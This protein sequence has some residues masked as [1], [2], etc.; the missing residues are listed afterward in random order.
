MEKIS[1]LIREVKSK[2]NILSVFQICYY[3]LT[4]IAIFY[5]IIMTFGCFKDI[6]HLENLSA[7]IVFIPQILITIATF[8]LTIMFTVIQN[9]SKEYSDFKNLLSNEKTKIAITL[10]LLS[11][12]AVFSFYLLKNGTNVQFENILFYSSIY[13]IFALIILV[14]SASLL[15]D[16]TN[17]IEQQ[18][19]ILM[20]KID[21]IPKQNR[22]SK[23]PQKVIEELKLEIE[24]IN[25]ISN[26]AIISKNR[27]VLIATLKVFKDCLFIYFKKIDA[28]NYDKF[29]AYVT[30]KYKELFETAIKSSNQALTSDISDSL[31]DILVISP[32]FSS[33]H[34][35]ETNYIFSNINNVVQYVIT[36]SLN[37]T[38]SY[39]SSLLINSLIK[40][41]IIMDINKDYNHANQIQ[42]F[43][44]NLSKAIT[45]NPELCA[46]REW[47]SS[48]FVDS[49]NG[50]LNHV[51]C[52]FIQTY[53]CNG[54]NSEF[55]IKAAINNLIKNIIFLIKKQGF[56]EYTSGFS[57]MQSIDSLNLGN[58]EF[59]AKNKI[60]FYSLLVEKYHYVEI[61]SVEKIIDIFSFIFVQDLTNAKCVPATIYYLEKLLELIKKV[62]IEDINGY[63]SD[64]YISLIF[65][66]VQFTERI[67]LNKAS[68]ENYDDFMDAIKSLVKVTL[69]DLLQ[70]I[71]LQIKK[72][73]CLSLLDK[74][75][76]PILGILINSTMLKPL[77]E[78]FIDKLIL[79]H[80]E[81][82]EE[83][84]EL[85]RQKDKL[86]KILKLIGFWYYKNFNTDAYFNAISTILVENFYEKVVQ[87]TFRDESDRMDELVYPHLEIEDYS[88][89]IGYYLDEHNI[90]SLS[91]LIDV[92][93]KELTEFNEFLKT[94]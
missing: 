1:N 54:I 27:T 16:E 61:P 84:A 21:K 49:T 71:K 24:I 86:Y 69:E 37:L 43:L 63:S 8:V 26:R 88:F 19:I 7:N 42:Q 75:I 46:N 82:P 22:Y 85:H 4:I 23:V 72:D 9:L 94:F 87:S 15:I 81:I 76:I 56:F 36:E 47:A 52:L 20:S 6:Q 45:T 31:S 70:L 32:E 44:F 41:M 64:I 89:L 78:E 51:F 91:K 11:F 93:F 80:N 25:R 74:E 12:Y 2:T 17:I 40:T 10:I 55:Y 77:T 34:L 18:K 92:D 50:I 83:D 59:E 57:L 67:E 90:N 73:S 68:I 39:A 60:N 30:S 66:I 33:G 48:L 38:D 62:K 35:T 58:F 29:V 53:K 5:V 14:F 3:S 13:F 65:L 79:L 28:T